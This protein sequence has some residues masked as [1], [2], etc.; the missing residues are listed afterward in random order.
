M[1]TVGV[2]RLTTSRDDH[3][4]TSSESLYEICLD[5]ATTLATDRQTCVQL[6]AQ[7]QSTVW[8]SAGRFTYHSVVLPQT[9][10]IALFQPNTANGKLNADITPTTPRGFQIS[11]SAWSF[12]E[13]TK[14]PKSLS[15][16]SD[17]ILNGTSTQLGYTVPFT[18]VHAGKYVTEDKSKTD[19]LQKL[20]TT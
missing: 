6:K 7:W 10:A 16:E 17:Q 8:H 11:R 15:L 18:S 19:T 9:R 12:P 2:K 14:P 5:V 13:M 4:M 20:N 1:A 3:I